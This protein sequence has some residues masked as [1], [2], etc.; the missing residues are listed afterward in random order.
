[1][2]VH[3]YLIVGALPAVVLGGL[4]ASLQWPFS[5]VEVSK[6]SP[7]VPDSDGHRIAE[8][9]PCTGCSYFFSIG[10]FGTALCN[11]AHERGD[12]DKSG[13]IGHQ[14]CSSG[15]QSMVAAEMARLAA[16]LAPSFV[17]SLG[18]NF[19]VRGVKD[20]E[21]PLFEASFES[22]YNIGALA[23]IPW[24]I[25]IGD[26]DQRGNVSALLLHSQRSS[27]WQLPSPYYKFQIRAPGGPRVDFL[28]TDSVGLEGS[29]TE[30]AAD[31]R[32]FAED[33]SEE[34]A[35]RAAGDAQWKWL[36]KELLEASA[37]SVDDAGDGAGKSPGLRVVIGHRPIVSAAR[38]G[39]TPLEGRTST[40]LRAVLARARRSG[41]LLYLSGHDHVMQHL[42]GKEDGIE[43]IGNGVGSF[44]HHPL[45]DSHELP[46]EFK[47]GS[48]NSY[49]FMVHEVNA[50]GMTTYFVDAGNHAVV[51]ATR[52]AF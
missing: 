44:A 11:E 41:P 15:R 38:R 42:K 23:A 48:D 45:E 1:M 49:G 46:G 31:F 51:H 20:L 12:T 39:R 8:A 10:D 17:L 25:S 43:F 29:V 33:Y 28:V 40:R 35:G 13:G 36:E 34:F 32:R 30:S 16:G 22:I 9:R 50:S 47:W 24:H 14:G 2:G 6:D 37:S 7:P 3:R 5:S 19:Y 18:D 27:R 26:H 4:L 52:I 21:D